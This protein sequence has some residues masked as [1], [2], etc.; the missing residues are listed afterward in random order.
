MSISASFLSTHLSR[1]MSKFLLY[2]TS[3]FKKNLPTNFLKVFS[4]FLRCSKRLLLLLKKFLDVGIPRFVVDGCFYCENVRGPIQ[5]HD[6]D[7]RNVIPMI[8][9]IHGREC[10]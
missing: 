8:Y 3:S 4:I 10:G 1:T 6:I 2:R 7:L 9:P 5:A